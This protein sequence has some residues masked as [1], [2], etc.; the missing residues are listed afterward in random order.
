[1]SFQVPHSRTIWLLAAASGL[2]L[3]LSFPPLP[4]GFIAFVG[5]VP[6]FFAVEKRS[7]GRTFRLGWFTGFVFFASLL[8]WIAFLDRESGPGAIFS[9]PAMFLLAMYQGFFIAM[10]AAGLKIARTYGRL[11]IWLVAP[12]IWVGF[13]YLRSLTFM[14]FPWGQLGYALAPYP[15]LIQYATVTSVLGSSFFL[16]LV[17]T[18]V[19]RMVQGSLERRRFWGWALLIVVFVGLV[20]LSGSRVMNR[21]ETRPTVRVAVIQPN[22][23]PNEKINSMQRNLETLF[24][25]SHLAVLEAPDLIVWPETALPVDLR[26]RRVYRKLVETFVRGIKIPLLTGTLDYQYRLDG[27][28]RVYNSAFFFDA[29]GEL[30]DDFAKMH[31]V[32]FGEMIPFEDRIEILQKVNLGEGAFSPGDRF[33]VFPFARAPFAVTICFEV[34]FPDQVRHFVLKG[35]RMLLNI[36]NDGWFGNTAGPHQHASMAVFRAVEN[37]AGLARA[38]NTGISMFIDPYG[39]VIAPTD[40]FTEGYRV[41]PVRLSTSPTFYTRFGDVFAYS[42]LIF[43]VTFVLIGFI[44]IYWRRRVGF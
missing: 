33:T 34:I 14:G 32:P 26:Y 43:A 17:N 24:R 6:F 10:F 28:Y 39:R 5:L 37:R 22:I 18:F 21:D 3:A 19:F 44:N 23:D 41:S 31:L 38:A 7:I 11:P 30:V 2:L 8:Y 20:H 9:L 25:L 35:A 13:E 29:S 15:T 4:F 27:Q 1:M 36:T 42:N 12:P 16:V 40:L